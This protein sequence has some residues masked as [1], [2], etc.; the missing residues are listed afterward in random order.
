[1][2][3]HTKQFR[4]L[5]V[6]GGT[7]GHFYPLIS[8]AEA[9]RESDENIALYYAGP[10]PYDRE[11]L[12]A[13]NIQFVSI[14]AGKRRRYFS[15]LNFLDPFKTFFGI[16]IA[17]IKL[18]VLY[19]DV[20]MSKG[21]YTSVPVVLAAAFLRIPIVVHES[22]SIPGAANKL[23]A[24][25]AHTVIVSYPETASLFP[26]P[27]VVYLGIPIRKALLLPPSPETLTTFNLDPNRPVVLILGGS[28]GAEM[29]NSLVLNSLDELL[30]D[31]S[32]IHQTGAH[33][34]DLCRTTADNLILDP[35]LRK[36]YHP[37]PFISGT[38]LN[39]AYHVARVVVSR[40]GSNSIH[41]IALHHKPS[42][43]IPIPEAVSH[44]QRTN[45]YTYARSG[46]ATVME[47]GNLTDTLLRTEIDRIMQNEDIYTEMVH[48]TQSF[49]KHN[50]AEAIRTLLLDIAEKH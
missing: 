43:L 10:D 23:A 27:N 41:E 24:R 21:G 44:D 39:D 12:S 15:L 45:A 26:H 16:G 22:D 18:F 5:L 8:I 30:T 3:S 7:G 19:P 36:N 2:S 29:I 28:Q 33:N 50:A 42:I 35:A 11:S 9:L 40:A 48:G 47:E 6:G 14:A 38:T 34:F 37:I 32:I 4:I 1:M 49:A 31:F 13:E 20:V 25:F 17:I 46:A